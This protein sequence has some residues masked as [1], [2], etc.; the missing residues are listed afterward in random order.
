MILL[1][2]TNPE[3][4]LA[5]ALAS[6][7]GLCFM[8]KGLVVDRGI[9]EDKPDSS[10]D[11]VLLRFCEDFVGIASV[12]LNFHLERH[13]PEAIFVDLNIVKRKEVCH[14]LAI[15]KSLSQFSSVKIYSI[16]NSHGNNSEMRIIYSRFCEKIYSQ[17]SNILTLLQDDPNPIRFSI[18]LLSSL[19]I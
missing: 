15:L 1:L 3:V 12:L 16:L 9:I 13:K 11:R 14:L 18:D 17:T 10:L 19:L 2:D 4:L 6:G 8:K 7:G 5:L